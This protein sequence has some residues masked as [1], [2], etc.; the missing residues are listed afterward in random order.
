LIQEAP[1]VALVLGPDD[2]VIGI[3]H[4]DHVARGLAPSPAFGPESQPIYAWRGV[5]FELEERLFKQVGTDMVE[6]R[7][8]PLL[9]PFPCSFPYAFQRL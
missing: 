9:L 8:E 5:F 6:E 4:D 3:A 2:E 1:G 7:G